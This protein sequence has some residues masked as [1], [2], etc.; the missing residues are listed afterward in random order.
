MHGRLSDQWD[1]AKAASMAGG[2]VEPLAACRESGHR[3]RKA[4]ERPAAERRRAG[5]V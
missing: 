1:D 2:A 4:E 5:I 3:Q